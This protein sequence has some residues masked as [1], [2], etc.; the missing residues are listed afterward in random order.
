MQSLG[1]FGD[2]YVHRVDYRTDLA[3]QVL[4][5]T[6]YEIFKKHIEDNIV[7]WYE[8]LENYTATDYGHGGCDQYY[9]YRQ[10]L[11]NH[12]KHDK[13]IVS[14]TSP[15]RWSF[16]SETIEKWIHGTNPATC[17]IKS[18]HQK[19]GDK[20]KYYKYLQDFLI[21]IYSEDEMKIRIIHRLLKDSMRKIR[22]DVIF[23]NGL[24]QYGDPNREEDGCLK[25]ITSYENK[26]IGNPRETNPNK[27]G[28]RNP[29]RGLF[30][31]SKR[32]YASKPK[33]KYDVRVA[34]I[35][36]PSHR[37]LAKKVATA[38]EKGLT[39]IK[40]DTNEFHRTFDEE[41]FKRYWWSQDDIVEYYENNLS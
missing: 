23:I 17:D 24:Y 37:I 20:R 1:V 34:H 21:H 27:L 11:E 15:H 30:D 9:I 39:Q 38:L 28:L 31:E 2:S 14:S 8:L 41:E 33:E 29:V 18:R 12:E 32:P 6:R 36:E 13:V 26:M 4:D 5:Q 16:F 3:K 10:F 22:P 7:I 25:N 19:F 35:T 40:I